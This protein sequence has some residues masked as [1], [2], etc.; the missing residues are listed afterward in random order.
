MLIQL[1]IV[2]FLTIMIHT[3]ETLS[4]AIRYAGV[5]TRKLAVSLTISGIVVLVSRTSN[6]VQGFLVGKMIDYAK[7]HPEFSLEKYFRVIIG[8][9]SIG[10]I[11]AML[12]FPSAVFLASRMISHLEVAGSVPKLLFGVSFTKLS[13]ARIHLRKPTWRMLKS[14][15]IYNIP[16]RL[17][18]L[19]CVVTSIYTVGVLAALYASFSA[20]SST[21]ASQSSGLI[22]GIATVLMTVLIDPQIAL[23]TDRGLHDEQDRERL[24]KVFGLMMLSRWVGTLLGQLVFLPASAWVV[25]LTKLI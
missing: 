13:H 19:N 4:Y 6:M 2:S 20:V 15:R 16:K 8:S 24:G 17:L 21:A 1:L 9:A 12:L 7:L 10:T 11:L 25:W 14:L 3:S 18:I 5:R 23:M 22:N